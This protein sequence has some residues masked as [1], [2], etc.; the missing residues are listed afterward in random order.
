M[1]DLEIK[2]YPNVWQSLGIV[3]ILILGMILFIPL[4]VILHVFIGEDAASLIYYLFAFGIPLWIVYSIRKR[5]TGNST[6]NCRIEN[7]RIVLYVIIAAVALAIGII[8]PIVSLIPMPEVLKDIFVFNP[9]FC[10]F[11]MLVIAAPFIEELI[12]RGIMLDGLLKLYS[13][14]KAIVI[15][16]VLFGFMHL[17]PWQFVGAFI[18]GVFIGWVYYHTRSLSLAIIMH[19]AHNLTSFLFVFIGEKFYGLDCATMNKMTLT[20]SYG[21][22]TNFVFITVGAIL[23]FVLSIGLLRK[24]FKKMKMNNESQK[25]NT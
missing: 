5:K 23:F 20:E 17:N 2:N 11:L 14:I 12:L 21:G 15:S 9:N 7:K 24:E 18:I 6:F 25:D 16:S 4:L 3:G 19:A 22:L 1:S 8:G 10:T 13:P